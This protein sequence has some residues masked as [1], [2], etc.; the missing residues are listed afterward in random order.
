MVLSVL[1]WIG[2]C[3]PRPRARETRTSMPGPGGEGQGLGG[4]WIMR[5][6]QVGGV[7]VKAE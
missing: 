4:E 1:V 5:Q 2:G 6:G 7:G 3:A